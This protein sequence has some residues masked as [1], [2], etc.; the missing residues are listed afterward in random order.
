MK[1]TRD[2][3]SDKIWQIVCFVWGVY[4]QFRGYVFEISSNEGVELCWDF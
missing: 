3:A 2:L 1:I 4:L